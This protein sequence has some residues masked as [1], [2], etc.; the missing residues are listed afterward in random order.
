M[1]K[2]TST[3]KRLFIVTGD[4]SADIHTAKV[5][6]TLKQHQ[7]DIDIH[8][9]GGPALAAAGMTLLSD[10]AQ[11]GQIGLGGFTSL[12][13]HWC[14][15]QR[16]FNYL[17]TFQPDAVLLVDYGGFNLWLASQLKKRGYRVFYFIPPQVWASRPWRLNA[18]A[19]A[20]DHVF[21]IFPFEV[22]LYEKKGIPVTFVGHPLVGHLPSAVDRQAFCET[23]GINPNH[24]LIGLLPGSRR[25]EIEALLPT[26][27]KSAV[28]LQAQSAQPLTF[29]LAKAGH[30]SVSFFQEQLAKA[31]E[32][33]NGASIQLTV[34]DHDAHA[35]QSVCDV[36][37][38][39]S[40]TATL[41]T[42]LYG[43]PMVIVYKVNPLF[44]WLA[45]QFCLLPVIGLPNVLFDPNHPIV[46]ELL[47]ENFTENQLVQT[48]LPLLKPNNPK[49]L[50]MIQGLQQ[51][52]AQV[53]NE[54][55]E[56]VLA[57]KLSALL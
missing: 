8:G 32:Q 42:A 33:L 49:R 40:G 2:S 41:E 19:K 20:V 7:P 47:Q 22:P 43:T 21:C 50:Q 45:K 30:L 29:L 18:M 9:V 28:A 26:I 16:I 11:L 56:I 46:P 15:G 57:D 24:T 3:H 36:V 54:L 48:V 13:H 31:S 6:A 5:V 39:K 4:V 27:L 37:I 14:L 12:W 10:Q 51:I 53:R 25:S 52:Q 44:G 38:C 34:I 35:V 23:H 55:F 1:A 17:N